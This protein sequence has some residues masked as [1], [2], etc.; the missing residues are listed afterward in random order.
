M[1]CLPPTTSA[2]RPDLPV[3]RHPRAVRRRRPHGVLQRPGPL[4][5]RA[6]PRHPDERRDAHPGPGTCRDVES[7]GPRPGARDRH[8]AGVRDP[9]QDRVRRQVRLRRHRQRHQ[10]RVAALLRR[11]AVADPHDRAGVHD[12]RAAVVGEDAGERQLRGFS[13]SVVRSASRA[14]TPPGSGHDRQ[15]STSEPHRSCPLFRR[16]NATSA[17]TCCRAGWPRCGR[18]CGST[19]PTSPWSWCRASPWTGRADSGTLTQAMEERFL[20]LLVLLRQPRLRMVYVTSLPIAPEIIEYYL[21]L[22]PGVI[23]S[24]AQVAALARVGQR[25]LAT[26]AERE[27]ARPAPRARPDR[28][29]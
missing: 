21:A 2:G 6:A 25:R 23:P 4:R 13:R 28:A 7:T 26:V 17:S 15:W 27:A 9:R 8:R 16:R 5:G 29:R 19:R 11:G 18:R 3:R 24:H 20:F 14:S 22:L 1:G 10:S 12:R